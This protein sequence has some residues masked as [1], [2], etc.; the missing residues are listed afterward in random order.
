MVLV[1]EKEQKI[2]FDNRIFKSPGRMEKS[3]YNLAGHRV[4]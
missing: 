4:K 1:G 3:Y 2:V